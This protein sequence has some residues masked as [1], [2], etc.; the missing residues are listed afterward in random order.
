VKQCKEKLRYVKNFPL[1]GRHL[2]IS[3]NFLFFPVPDSLTILGACKAGFF[4]IL[5]A[6][7]DR[8]PSLGIY[9]CSGKLG[10]RQFRHF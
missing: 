4:P 8:G 2:L 9:I 1:E 7:R 6:V 5:N 10:L 3:D